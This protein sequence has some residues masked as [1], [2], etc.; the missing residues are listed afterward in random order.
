MIDDSYDNNID[1]NIINYWHEKFQLTKNDENILFNPNGWLND[2]HLATA[3]QILYVQKLQL[4]GYQQHTH[5]IIRIIHKYP[6][7]YL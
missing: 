6:T 7:N 1:N 4:L 3:M 2:Q 5:T